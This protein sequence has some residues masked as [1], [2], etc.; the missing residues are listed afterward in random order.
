MISS[1]IAVIPFEVPATLKSISPTW[2]S[3]PCM[4]VKVTYSLLSPVINPTEIPATGE[5]IGT[6]ASIK[7][8]VPAQTLPI[9]V[10]P[11]ELRAS[12]TIRIVYGKSS[13]LGRTALNALSARAPWP[14]SL[15]PGEPTLPASPTEYGG[16]L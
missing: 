2:S 7:D 8:S 6:P 13:A 15:L 11:F 3:R 5:E 16:K 10:L 1:C 14:T 9:D 12:Q 4:S